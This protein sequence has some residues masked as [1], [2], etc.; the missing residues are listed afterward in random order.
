MARRKKAPTFNAHSIC[1]PTA[2]AAMLDVQVGSMLIAQLV[3]LYQSE[4]V[5]EIAA[6]QAPLC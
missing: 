1:P 2:C 3:Q 6:K 5:N 4:S